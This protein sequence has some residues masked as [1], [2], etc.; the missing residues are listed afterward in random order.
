MTKL[1]EKR[2]C[3]LE[4][5][6]GVYHDRTH[7]PMLSARILA[8]RRPL[9]NTYLSGWPRTHL[10]WNRS[11]ASHGQQSSGNAGPSPHA[12]FYRETLPAM[13]PVALLGSA[14]YFVS[15]TYLLWLQRVE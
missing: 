13:A 11:D 8:L 5:T 15:Q 10:R 12:Q 1:T 14:A 9:N 6:V 7:K 3:Q 2:E 4:L